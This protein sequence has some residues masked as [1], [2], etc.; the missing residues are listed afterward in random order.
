MIHPVAELVDRQT[1]TA[2]NLLSARDFVVV[3]R[4]LQEAD[5]ED[6]RVVPAFAQGRV[7]EDEAHRFFRMYFRAIGLMR[8]RQQ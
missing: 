7:R 5:D 8:E 2:T 4:M 3:V 6:I 1:Q